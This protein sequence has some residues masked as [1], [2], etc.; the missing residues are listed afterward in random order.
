MA[1]DLTGGISSALSDTFNRFNQDDLNKKA[2][3][4]KQE[5]LKYVRDRNAVLDA[6][7]KQLF[8]MKIAEANRLKQQDNRLG[9]IMGKLSNTTAE[10]VVSTPGNANEV[11]AQQGLNQRVD[12]RLQ[13]YKQNQD[14]KY[15]DNLFAALD[16]QNEA[17]M[18]VKEGIMLSKPKDPRST[19]YTVSPVKGTSNEVYTT[20]EGE[21]LTFDPESA[22]G[23][24]LYGKNTGGGYEQVT[25]VNAVVGGE[26]A[27]KATAEMERIKAEG[28]K[29][30]DKR[31]EAI[32]SS[33][34]DV[35]KLVKPSKE[36]K[37]VKL[38]KD[39]WAQNAY[40][41][42]ASD[43][44]LSGS[45]KA[46]AINSLNTQAELLFGKSKEATYDQIFKAK[47]AIKEEADARQT[48]TAIARDLNIRIPNGM[49]GK[50]ALDYVKNTEAYKTLGDKKKYNKYGAGPET[51]KAYDSG[52]GTI[53]SDDQKKIE[54]AAAKAKLTD[55]D[56]AS[57]ITTMNT[58][59]LTP[60]FSGNV[61]EDVLD[62]INRT[63][64]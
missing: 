14:N 13:N 56:L 25:P 19:G 31:I 26:E 15:T 52:L 41:I 47:K 60:R 58:K 21:R 17:L 16:A 10:Q 11:A 22:V 24:L 5:Q 27:K 59:D 29:F 1:I 37:N 57:I 42:I 61:T 9:E 35:D 51:L 30:N 40:N 48:S 43:P 44:T 63:S 3:L 8:D 18:N 34:V 46:K 32:N 12:Q 7:N 50:S 53:D 2:E 39:E 62:Y 64:K 33:R 28:P 55:K 23:K 49:S 20:T 4:A 38:T 54:K 36:I 6:Q 45:A